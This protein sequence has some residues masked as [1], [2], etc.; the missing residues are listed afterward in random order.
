M[1]KNFI[2]LAIAPRVHWACIPCARHWLNPEIT[3]A[4]PLFAV[5]GEGMQ[6]E[7]LVVGGCGI[8]FEIAGMND[9]PE[10]RMHGQRHAIHQTM[11]DADGMDGER[12]E[13][14]SLSRANFVQGRIL[15]QT[16]F[17]QLVFHISQGELGAIHRY[18]QL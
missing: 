12:P 18:I 6:I 13:F 4:H 2:E 17:L 15:E 14:E 5:F 9:Y 3:P 11:G 7:K 8:D 10:R 16:V 1:H